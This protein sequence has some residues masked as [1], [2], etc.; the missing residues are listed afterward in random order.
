MAT[1]T[2][3]FGE[4]ELRQLGRAV[5]GAREKAGL[6][7]TLLAERAGLSIRPIRELE[8]GRSSPSLATIVAVVDALSMTLDGLIAAARVRQSGYG[9]LPAAEL[10]RGDN[11]LAA[12]IDQPRLKVRIVDL[13]ASEHVNLPAGPVFAHV[14]Q[15]SIS[16]TLDDKQV[17]LRGGDSLHS[18]PGVLTDLS[19]ADGQVRV[20]LVEAL[21]TSIREHGELPLPMTE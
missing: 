21:D 15:G 13:D 5:R 6:S 9:L 7:Q 16:A 4:R 12:S 11:G 8:A 20:L 17:K 19:A 18:N 2:P 1:N 3:L 10:S 14:L